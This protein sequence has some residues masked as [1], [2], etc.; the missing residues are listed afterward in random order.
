MKLKSL[1]SSLQAVLELHGNVT[2]C[3]LDEDYNDCE[4]HLSYHDESGVLTSVS[5]ERVKKV[6]LKSE[7]W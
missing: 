3:V 2:V 1:I 4:P 5:H 6:V 7:G